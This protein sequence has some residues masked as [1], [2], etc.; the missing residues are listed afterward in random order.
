MI[1]ET[2]AECGIKMKD[3]LNLLHRNGV[4]RNDFFISAISAAFE[5]VG[6]CLHKLLMIPHKT[7]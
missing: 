1:F 5:R 3:W 6:V 4:V 2:P 7:V